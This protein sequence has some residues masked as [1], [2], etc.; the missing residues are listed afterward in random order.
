[1]AEA[2]QTLFGQAPPFT[3]R[4]SPESIDDFEDLSAKF[5]D[6]FT[7]SKDFTN[8]NPKYFMENMYQL[9]TGSL[10]GYLT[11]RK[12]RRPIWGDEE[13]SESKSEQEVVKIL[14]VQL[15]EMLQM[16]IVPIGIV[17]RTYFLFWFMLCFNIRCVT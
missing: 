12:L 14:L 8:P 13:C 2:E 10:D 6:R 5:L 17:S 1:M 9:E 11:R 15:L 7:L 3:Q 4:S 16:T